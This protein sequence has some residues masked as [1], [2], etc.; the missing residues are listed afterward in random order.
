MASQSNWR[1]SS[2]QNKNLLKTIE[3][4]YYINITLKDIQDSLFRNWEV[5]RK[6]IAWTFRRRIHNKVGLTLDLAGWWQCGRRQGKASPTEAE[7]RDPPFQYLVYLFVSPLIRSMGPLCIL[8]YIWIKDLKPV[9]STAWEQSQMSLCLSDMYL[10]TWNSH[11][12]LVWAGIQRPFPAFP[13]TSKWVVLKGNLP[14]RRR[15]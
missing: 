14:Q 3:R 8:G 7:W 4:L 15:K 11:S 9:S 13:L 1:S 10:P 12:C 5:K 6:L 2:T